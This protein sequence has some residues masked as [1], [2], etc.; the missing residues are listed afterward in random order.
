MQGREVQFY[1][2]KTDAKALIGTPGFAGAATDGAERAG[3][4]CGWSTTPN[5]RG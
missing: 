3:A 2:S 1:L 4:S 5:C